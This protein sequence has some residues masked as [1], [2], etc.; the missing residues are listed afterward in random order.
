LFREVGKL[1]QLVRL[2]NVVQVPLLLL[3]Q[4]LRSLVKQPQHL[5]YEF[6]HRYQCP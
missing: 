1:Q 4:E 2:Q 3:K 6:F 5:P